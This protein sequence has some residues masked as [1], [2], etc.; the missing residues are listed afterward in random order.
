MFYIKYNVYVF[1]SH[2]TSKFSLKNS[3]Q[4]ISKFTLQPQILPKFHSK[5]LDIDFDPY[6]LNTT[7]LSQNH[8]KK[9]PISTIIH[10]KILNKHA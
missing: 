4:K 6:S 1:Y 7:F 3:T 8:T 10:I 2:V 5:M 9:S